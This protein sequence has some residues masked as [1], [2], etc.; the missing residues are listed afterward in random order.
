MF[1]NRGIQ[2]EEAYFG[3]D[4]KRTLSMDGVSKVKPTFD[5]LGRSRASMTYRKWSTA[6][7]PFSHTITTIR[8]A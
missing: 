5:N 1:D 7:R 6:S 4:G 8:I 2:I 3:V